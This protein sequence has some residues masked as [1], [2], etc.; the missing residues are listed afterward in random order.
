MKYALSSQ[1]VD[2]LEVSGK[3]NPTEKLRL[4]DILEDTEGNPK[5][6][7]T[8]EAIKKEL[9][10]L[11]IVEN[12]EEPFAVKKEETRA[13]YTRNESNQ[14]RYDNRSRYDT[15]RKNIKNDGYK[16]S[17]TNPQYFRTAS[18]RKW[19]RDDSK[20]GGRS[21]S[22]PSSKPRK[23]SR[24]GSKF[25]NRSKSVDRPKSDLMK[26]IE[27]IEKDSIAMKTCIKNVEEMVK[28][29]TIS[30]KYVE[31]EIFIDVKYVEKEIKNVMIVDSGAPV[32]LMSSAW[33]RNYLRETKVDNEEV[34][35]SSSN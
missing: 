10:R 21:S 18:R 28:K 16:R 17:E 11:K 1:F 20:F 6:G 2:R 23:D 34:Q 25:R 30:T 13:Y 15:W 14:N 19:L 4:K 26:K 35:K 3:I 5:A 9:K 24:P 22:R 29:L 12:R 27:V 33:F 32:S 31:E 8:T 7:E